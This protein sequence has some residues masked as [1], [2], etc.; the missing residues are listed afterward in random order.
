MPTFGEIAKDFKKLK[1]ID[2][3]EDFAKRKTINDQIINTIKKRL[4]A[5][6]VTGD[7][8]KLRTDNALS[9]DFYSLLTERV[10]K[11]EGQ[12]IS[13]VTLKDTGEF[14]DSFVTLINKQFLIIDADF[15]K[16]DGHIQKN[17]TSQ[18]GTADKFEESVLSLTDEELVKIIL[19]Q[20][21]DYL[22]KQLHNILVK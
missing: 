7:G 4:F 16:D 13:N 8:V 14:Y 15:N 3:F 12:K 20:F 9:G 10:K 11:F 19:D 2:L 5:D 6:G 17:F 21:I 18:F 22:N 1:F